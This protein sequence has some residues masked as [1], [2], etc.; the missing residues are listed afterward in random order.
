MFAQR[1]DKS[2]SAWSYTPLKYWP[3][4]VD[5][6][7]YGKVSFFA[8]APAPATENGITLAGGSGYTGYPAFT[9]TPPATL[10]N[11]LDLCVAQ[12][13][14]LTKNSHSGKVPL[15]FAH[16]MAKVTF[17][18][19]YTAKLDA[20]LSHVNIQK[21]EVK[22]LYGSSTLSFD[23]SAAGYTWGT[24][25][26]AATY[27]LQ[28]AAL[29]DDA[30]IRTTHT[31]VSTDEGTLML[32]PQ[33]TPAAKLHVNFCL[34][35]VEVSREVDMTSFTLAAGKAYNYTL[36]LAGLL[37]PQTYTFTGAAETFTA[38]YNGT[39]L[40]EV[41]GA[42]ARFAH[43]NDATIYGKG[44]YSSGKIAL[45][46]G[47]ELYVYVGER[48]AGTVQ[49]FNG[50]GKGA[51]GDYKSAGGGGATD[52][53]ITGTTLYHRLIVAGGGGGGSDRNYGAGHGGGL[54]G[55]KGGNQN[56]SNGSGGNPGTQIAGGVSTGNGS[57]VGSFGTGG[58]A[59]DHRGGAGGG[60]WY[61]GSASAGG[62]GVVGSGGGGS[63]WVYTEDAF[64]TWQT[65]NPT[66]AAQ[67]E[68]TSYYYLT[69]A[70]TV[71]GNV[72]NGMPD[73]STCECVTMTGNPGNGFARITLVQ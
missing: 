14:D 13:T 32:V 19:K 66:D 3:D 37:E 50:G 23:A 22:G 53:R 42:G 36:T 34:A 64:N 21:I 47:D 61:G 69:D 57:G 44:G 8:L 11:Q 58:N 5:G 39:Y 24:P 17:A 43:D 67:Y 35:G 40:L 26:G 70:K 30:L 25:T 2:G 51:G 6:A 28:D 15:T 54:T 31:A 60:G 45:T 33:T 72:T 55:V 18:A 65:G 1:V 4:L 59:G 16:T 9:V 20:D 68:L 52:I 46:A 29:T 56:G 38:P 49:P 7:N 48:P 12:A 62:N 63:G 27:T 10:A 73:W 41:W 71:A